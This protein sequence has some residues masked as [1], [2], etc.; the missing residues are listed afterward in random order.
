M[1]QKNCECCILGAG[2][3]GLGAALE[4]VKHGVK[5]VVVLDRNAIV[6]GLARTEI[7]GGARFDIGPHRFY[8]K[9]KEIHALWHDLLKDDLRPVSR[10]TRICYNQKFFR[11]PV[12]VFDVLYQLGPR[13]SAEAAASYIKAHFTTK[14]EPQTFE[15]W[16]T[17]KF[18]RKL[19]QSFFKTYTE[20]IWGL[21]C[22]EIGAEWASQRIKGLDAL[23][24]LKNA[25]RIQ[26]RDP[27]KTLI[28]EFDYP[29]K[30]A[31]QMY[32]AMAER[33]HQ[34]GVKICLNSRV[35][36]LEQGS[37]R[38]KSVAVLDEKKERYQITARHYFSSIPL[39]HF[40]KM[41]DPPEP[42]AV[43][44]AEKSLYYREHI[45]VNLLIDGKNLFKDQWLYIHSADV[46]TARVTNYN[47]FSEVM[48]GGENQT[49]LSMEYFTFQN[50]A[51]WQMSDGDLKRL[52]AEEL[53]CLGLVRKE[54]IMQ[55]WVVRE[56]GA[57]PV[58]Y[59]DYQPPFNVLK[60]RIDQFSNLS[61]IGRGGMYKYNNQD[62][63]TLSG[64]LAARNYLKVSDVVHRLW[65][66]NV[67]D[68]YLEGARRLKK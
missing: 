66:I 29:V 22:H 7:F 39:T 18:G 50:E 52:A 6:G 12:Q 28:Q 36:S 4:L 56:T 60:T 19:Y 21:P 65:D 55:A 37:D 43:Q 9:N 47:N 10:L 67:E 45:T 54:R 16:V 38:I 25:L 13:E 31:G 23:T 8:T 49:A 26:G 20:K 34:A 61:P 62:H 63:A 5:D 44:D 14:K 46:K 11:Y 15:D 57:Y 53:A 58:Y 42:P 41:L 40:F 17:Q 35:V 24:V 64:M 48:A 33:L 51:L 32:E 59:R 68:D 2:P 30:G 1:I 3:A 27:V